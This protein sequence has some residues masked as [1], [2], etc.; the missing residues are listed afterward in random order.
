MYR[1]DM[2]TISYLSQIEKRLGVPT[3]I[4][5]WNTILAV[6]RILKKPGAACC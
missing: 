2:K 1:R 5:N 6:A 3:T 4:R